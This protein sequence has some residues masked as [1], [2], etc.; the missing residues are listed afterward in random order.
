MFTS[1]EK[2][3]YIAKQYSEYFNSNEKIIQKLWEDYFSEFFDYKKLFGE[4]DSQ[5]KIPIGSYERVIPDIILRKDNRDLADVELKMYSL[6]FNR[7]MEDQLKS[8][9]K[10]IKLSVGVI[11]CEKIYL[12]WYDYL[13]DSLS[14]VIINF[15]KNNFYGIK[16]IELLQKDNFQESAIREFIEKTEQYKKNVQKI[17]EKLCTDYV[18]EIIIENLQKDYDFQEIQEALKDIEIKIGDRTGDRNIYGKSPL[19]S[20][21]IPMQDFPEGQNFIIIKTSYDRV[22]RCQGNLYDATRHSWRVKYDRVIQ[23]PYVLSVIDGIVKEVY[24]VTAWREAEKW[25]IDDDR[26]LGRLEFVGEIAPESIRRS[27]LGKQ[28]PYKYRKP[29]M[30]SPVVFSK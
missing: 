11:I 3:N 7:S 29:G 22:N 5:R 27:F 1:E 17:R 25:D 14:K 9:L 16:F 18:R 23:Y 15:E 12:Y 30:A 4:I 2:W 24:R 28:I 26:A 20:P 21:D 13:S 19:P 6:S 8:Y 10:L